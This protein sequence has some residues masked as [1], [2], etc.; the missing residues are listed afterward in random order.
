[1]TAPNITQVR[2]Y[3]L[4]SSYTQSERERVAAQLKLNSLRRTTILSFSYT[5]L[6]LWRH[7]AHIS[8][9]DFSKWLMN[10]AERNGFSSSFLT[11]TQ[12][13]T[14]VRTKIHVAVENDTINLCY[15][16]SSL[17]FKC[18]FSSSLINSVEISWKKKST[19]NFCVLPLSML[20]IWEQKREKKK[21]QNFVH[22]SHRSMFVNRS[23]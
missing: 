15:L 23:K 6:P 17:S 5:L 19:V 2:T 10:T 3:I 14:H 7:H 22:N 8:L 4:H 13:T 1:M 16:F 11:H 9:H 18:L 20:S 21:T 12:C